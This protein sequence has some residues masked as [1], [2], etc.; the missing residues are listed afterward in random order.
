[1]LRCDRRAYTSRALSCRSCLS[2]ALRVSTKFWKSATLLLFCTADCF[3]ASILMVRRNSLGKK[4]ACLARTRE[5]RV[6]ERTG[7]RG[8]R[9][10]P[11]VHHRRLRSRLACVRVSPSSVVAVRRLRPPLRCVRVNRRETVGTMD[12]EPTVSGSP[13]AGFRHGDCNTSCL[14]ERC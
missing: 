10:P 9:D 4:S 3:F 12:G 1:M 7:S 2:S 6:G 14:C 5:L 11:L 8:G 13:L